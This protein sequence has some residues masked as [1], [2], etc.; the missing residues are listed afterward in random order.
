MGWKVLDN[1][2]HLGSLLGFHK[3]YPMGGAE[4]FADQIGNVRATE[5]MELDDDL[6]GSEGRDEV[7]VEKN[8]FAAF[9]VH[10]QNCMVRRSKNLL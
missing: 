5:V 9:A 6:S 1:V 8:R 7:W 2:R 4:S 3:V 10:D